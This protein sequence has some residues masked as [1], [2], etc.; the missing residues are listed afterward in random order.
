MIGKTY[1]CLL[2]DVP[3]Y[4]A[5]IEKAEGCWATVKVIQPKPGKYER[6]YQPGQIFDIKIQFYD[7]IEK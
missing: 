5:I 2:N 4:D 1:T 3:L 6:Q 7:F